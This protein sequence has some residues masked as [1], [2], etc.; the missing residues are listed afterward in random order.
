MYLV[1]RL[2]VANLGCLGCGVERASRTVPRS[3]YRVGLG[4]VLLD[5]VI[6]CRLLVAILRSFEREESHSKPRNALRKNWLW[7][8]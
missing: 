8:W 1:E 4:E 3:A 7:N 5:V 6:V 2:D